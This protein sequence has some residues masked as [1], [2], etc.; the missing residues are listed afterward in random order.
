[1]KYF[2]FLIM[3]TAIISGCGKEKSPKEV[4]SNFLAHIKNMDFE[5]AAKLITDES[6][7]TFTKAKTDFQNSESYNTEF[8]NSKTVTPDEILK[9]LDFNDAFENV[10]GSSAIVKSNDSSNSINLEKA[11]GAWKIV[12]TKKL[13]DEILNEPERRKAVMDSY[14]KLHDVYKQ[15]AYAI[16]RFPEL[17]T[18]EVKEKINQIA[19]SGQSISDFSSFLDQQQQLDQILN[20]TISGLDYS[21]LPQDLSTTLETLANRITIVRQ[22]F[23]EK[24]AYYNSGWGK[25]FEYIMPDSGSEKAP[26]VR[27]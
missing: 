1:M 5:K 25:K 13:M 18:S 9:A 27:F 7:E 10:S 12:C 8:E 22:D 6:K 21:L 2:S 15:K 23:N 24:V 17:A 16:L 14:N 19:S 4:A 20:R 3:F 11:N 26:E